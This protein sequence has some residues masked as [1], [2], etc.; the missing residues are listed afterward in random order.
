MSKSRIHAIDRAQAA[1]LGAEAVAI[2]RAGTYRVGDRD[3]AIDALVERAVT[4]TCSYPVGTRLPVV[5]AVA[6]PTRISVV[7]QTTLAA[8]RALVA[9]GHD[10][11]ALN[12]ASATHP[13]GGFLS[14]ARAQEESLCRSSALHACLVGDAMYGQARGYGLY[15]SWVVYSPAVPVFRDDDG[16]LLAAPYPVSFL[17]CAAVNAKVARAHL[18]DDAIRAA[19]ARRIDRV[20]AVAAAQGHDT[21]VLGAWGCGAFGNDPDTIA[22]LFAA[23]LADRFRDRFATIVFAIVDDW[24]DRRN[25][26]PFE[27]RFA[28]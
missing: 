21:L 15:T 17:T 24:A 12:F 14:G 10:V 5:E 28:G 26:G 6:T 7:N 18:G 13:G 3:V 1:A 19:M 20:L 16:A 9:A 22:A 25:I 11:A 27:A 23:A 2:T 8:A 4:G